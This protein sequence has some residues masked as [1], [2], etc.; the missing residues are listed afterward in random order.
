MNNVSNMSV[1]SSS[2][3]MNSKLKTYTPLQMD[4]HSVDELL[5]EEMGKLSFQA[6]NAIYEEIHGVGS[7]APEETPELI[8]RSLIEMSNEIDRIKHKYTAYV[9]ATT[10]TTTT[11]TPMETSSSSS[12][13][14]ERGTTDTTTIAG[15]T[16]PLYVQ[17]IDIRLRFLRCELFNISKAAVRMLTYLDLTRELFG[18]VILKRPIQL[19]DLGKLEMEMLRLGDAQPISFRDRSGRRL[20]VAMN[21]FGLQYPLEVR[22]RIRVLL[23]IRFVHLLLIAFA[24]RIFIKFFDPYS[25]DDSSPSSFFFFYLKTHRSGLL[26]ICIG[27]WVKMKN[28]KRR[29]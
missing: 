20:M 2:S 3:V 6:R 5:T 4:P 25:Y 21:N 24:P 1:S 13:E 8:Q 28:L 23:H 19:S 29:V 27:L 9:E 11:T 22:V 15:G 16:T 18:K 14:E 12:E 26:Y 17:D 10:T 7:L